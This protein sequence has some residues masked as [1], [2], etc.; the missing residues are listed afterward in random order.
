M[1]NTIIFSK[2]NPQGLQELL[3]SIETYWFLHP[4]INILV[5][6]THLEYGKQYREIDTKNLMNPYCFRYDSG[7][8][9]KDILDIT[10]HMGFDYTMFLTDQD[11]LINTFVMEAASMLRCDGVSGVSCNEHIPTARRSLCIHGVIYRTK[12]VVRYI[13]GL[14]PVENPG[15]LTSDKETPVIFSPYESYVET[16]DCET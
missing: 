15:D 6:E 14:S 1:I 8:L 2:N 5:K 4:L 9:K 3:D 11:R 10:K 12:D 13:K 16:I 7:D